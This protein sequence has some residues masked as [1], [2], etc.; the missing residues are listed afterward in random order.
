MKKKICINEIG[1]RDGFQ[2]V[3]EFIPTEIK[4]RIIDGIVASG[5]KRVQLTSF[6]SPKAIP[7]MRDSAEVVSACLGKYPDMGFYA[8]VPNLKGAENA[9]NCGL[10]EISAVISV[11]ESHNMANVRKTVDES[12]AQLKEMISAFPEMHI[13][14][15]AATAFGC[16]V[17]GAVPYENLKSYMARAGELGIRAVTLCDTTGVANPNQIREYLTR[18]CADLPE[19]TLRA[20]I[21]DTRNMGMI[22]SLAAIECGVTDVEAAL[23][24]LG[25]CPF[26]EGA[27]GN[28]STEDFVYMLQELGYDTG[29]D[30]DKLLEKAKYAK[31]HVQ[32]NFSGHHINI[33]RHRRVQ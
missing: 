26:A 19:M 29:I 8:L 16:P 18:L 23:G 31:E 7:Q 32:G 3:E 15:D 6:V 21:H 17:E 28:T 2:N 9:A 24:G 25:G 11:S 1:P 27:S 4:L 10:K 33:T 14:L 12:F 5:I 30:F 13:I 22:N 20:H